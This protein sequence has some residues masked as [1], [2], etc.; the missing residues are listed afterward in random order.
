MVAVIKGRFVQNVDI[1]H[2]SYIVAYLWLSAGNVVSHI[3]E[4][5]DSF[6]DSNSKIGEDIWALLLCHMLN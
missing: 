4:D 1:L 3:L 6:D 5:E 2:I